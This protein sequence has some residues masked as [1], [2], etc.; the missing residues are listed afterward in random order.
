MSR[1][2]IDLLDLF[3][4]HAQ[5]A[6]EATVIMAALATVKIAEANEAKAKLAAFEAN[7]AVARL[8]VCM[9]KTQY[10]LT[11]DPKLIGRPK[12]WTNAYR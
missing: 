10:S 12:G 2:G 9:A 4:S 3:A 6:G 1:Q 8:P 5:I 7:P 11:H